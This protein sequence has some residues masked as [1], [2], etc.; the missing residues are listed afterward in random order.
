MVIWIVF[1]GLSAS[2]L[3]G[4][5]DRAVIEDVLDHTV[6]C[7]HRF[8]LAFSTAWPGRSDQAGSVRLGHM[9]I[10]CSWPVSVWRTTGY[11]CHL[12]EP[13]H[14]ARHPLGEQLMFP[15]IAEARSSPCA[16][17]R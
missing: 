5:R 2:D 10:M 9:I 3:D 16:A 4:D 8:D 1:M 13:G 14:P 15:W 7:A 12:E 17:L 11:C 6:S